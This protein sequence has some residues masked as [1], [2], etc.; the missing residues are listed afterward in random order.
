MTR[1]NVIS[2]GLAGLFGAILLTGFC[3]FVMISGWVPPLVARPFYVWGLFLFLLFF[4]VAEIP[5]MIYGMRRMA[6]SPN[7]RAKTLALLT[8]AG[9]TFFAAVYAAPFILLAGS[10]SFQ[11]ILGALMGG[12]S[13]V[14]FTTAILFLPND[15]Q[16]IQT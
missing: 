6:D 13:L 12:L 9:F 1:S 8:N 2:T 4:S 11:L 10:S 14:R 3:L 7:P 5:V 16:P 15:Q